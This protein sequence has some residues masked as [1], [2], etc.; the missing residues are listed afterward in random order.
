M[1]TKQPEP[2]YSSLPV[3]YLISI[4]MPAYNAGAYIQAAIHSVLTQTYLHWELIIVNDHSSDNTESV[5]QAFKDH[6]IHYYLAPYHFGKPSTARNYAVQYA[7]GQFVFFLDADD[8]LLAGALEN[9]VQYVKSHPG[10]M[11]AYGFNTQIN[12]H[13]QPIPFA[14]FKLVP[15]QDGSYQLPENYKHT[16]E[17]IVCFKF[18]A[19]A[20]IVVRKNIFE[21]LGGFDEVLDAAEDMQLYFKLFLKSLDLVGIIPQYLVA[22]RQHPTSLTK[23]HGKAEKLLQ[24]H[25]KMTDW[26]F[27][28][29]QL[30]QHCIKYRPFAISKAYNHAAGVR[31]SQ[32]YRQQA[33]HLLFRGLVDKRSSLK[34]WLKV[35]PTTL[36]RCILPTNWDTQLKS[37]VIN[38]RDG[39]LKAKLKQLRDKEISFNVF[40]SELTSI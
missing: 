1:F 24:A 37:V 4:I 21:E 28:N 13:G 17:R 15:C 7:C 27:S 35:C 26:L 34:N 9:I 12:E 18:V 11:A 2:L 33:C 3:D 38:L 36:L 32:G 25:L 39:V 30:P 8:I 6:R 20:T 23:T 16:W 14:G 40:L 29:P 22:Y 19:S 10:M 31:L 5:I